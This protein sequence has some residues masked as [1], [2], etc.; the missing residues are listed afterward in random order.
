M[1]EMLTALEMIE[2]HPCLPAGMKKRAA[3]WGDG[4]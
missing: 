3:T 4:G 2:Q 1:R